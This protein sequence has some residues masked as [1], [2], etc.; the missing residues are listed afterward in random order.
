MNDNINKT[1]NEILESYSK[2]EQT[3]RLSEDN[4]INKS[5]LIQCLKK[6]ASCCFRATLTRTE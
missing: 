3:C 2:H 4:I 5:V 6:S 1:V